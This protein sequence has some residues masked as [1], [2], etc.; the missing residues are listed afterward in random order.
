MNVF[1]EFAITVL[2]AL[3]VGGLARV[4]APRFRV[5]WPLAPRT[6][7]HLFVLLALGYILTFG[8]LSLLRHASFHSGG[9]DLG[10]FDQTIW[11]SLQGRLFERSITI[12]A[13]VS[14]AEHFSPILLALVPLYAIWSDAQTLLI[15][16]TVMLALSALP[17]YWFARQKLGAWLALVV[18]AAYFLSPALQSVNLFEFHEVALTALLLNFAL[19]FLLRHRTVPFLICLGLALTTKEEVAFIVAAFGFYV[20]FVDRKRGLG[21][22]LIALGVAWAVA[23]LIWII[24]S[25]RDP[26]HGT[27]YLYANRYAYLG[28]S[29]TDI[30]HTAITQPGL[31]LQHLLVPA[32]IE[33]VLQLLVPLVFLPLGGAEIFALALPT[34][35][36]LL[37]TD[38]PSNY[39]IRFQYTAPLLPFIFFAAV[40][41]IAR[42]L[43]SPRW[44]QPVRTRQFIFGAVVGA[45]CVVNYLFQSP[46]PLGGY[47]DPT[48][49]AITA[50]TQLGHQL[51]ATIPANASVMADSNLAPHVTDRRY[52]YQPS[53]VPDLRLIDYLLTDARLPPRDGSDLIWRDVL[54]SPF[55]ETVVA[56]D[57]YTLK[58][59]APV[60][61]ARPTQ[62]QFD[63]RIRLLGYTIESS[64]PAKPG[65]VAQ[66]I[67]TWRADQMI[68][69]RYV[70][71]IH[72]VD[73]NDGIVAQADQE[74]ANG[75]LRTDR[76][77]IGD[78]TPDRFA[79]EL[80]VA[81]APGDYR[82]QTGFYRVGDQQNLV[83]RDAQGNLLGV[84][85]VIGTLSVR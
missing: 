77:N 72:L 10:V 78:V 42:L 56:Q 75:W 45:A 29:V 37:I 41:G 73:A 64:A 11:N 84:A 35:G 61:F 39:S 6:A 20:F 4:I 14:L 85:P 67:L 1:V 63:E 19:Y 83:A 30:V 18:A 65:T 47:F 23:T 32:K 80:P 49:Y 26:I 54:A 36:Y 53:V 40:V 17:L 71:F 82:I 38:F 59:R 34:F 69:E 55:Y 76:W 57:G 48:Q 24:P 58:K 13:R 51:I 70:A 7:D 50:H 62:I 31:V 12:D 74:P 9:Y 79:L 81:L 52:A 43:Q 68:R 5:T 60:A 2:V 46:G 44:K 8:T 22:S 33:F 3:G 66:I 27:N 16:Q 28:I 15:L 25:F 21:A